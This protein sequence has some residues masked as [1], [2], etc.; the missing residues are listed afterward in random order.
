MYNFIKSCINSFSTSGTIN[1][2][3]AP[4]NEFV[5]CSSCPVCVSVCLFVAKKTLKFC[6]KKKLKIW[7]YFRNLS[8]LKSRDFILDCISCDLDLYT[9]IAI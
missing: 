2:F 4:G 5:A 3:Y 1:Y 8:Y 9:K 7:P 6:I